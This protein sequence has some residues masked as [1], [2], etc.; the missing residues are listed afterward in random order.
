M[1]DNAQLIKNAIRELDMMLHNL[2]TGNLTEDEV[3]VHD[4]I[5]KNNLLLLLE[6]FENNT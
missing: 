6:R 1:I 2:M 3:P 4:A 5:I